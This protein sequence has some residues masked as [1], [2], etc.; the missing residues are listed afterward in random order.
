M[1]NDDPRVAGAGGSLSERVA[2]VVLWPF[3]RRA[4]IVRAE[5]GKRPMSGD[6]R[7]EVWIVGEEPLRID[8]ASLAPTGGGYLAARVAPGDE[9]DHELPD[10]AADGDPSQAVAAV[11]AVAAGRASD[12]RDASGAPAVRVVS[13]VGLAH[14]NGVLSRCAERALTD[15]SALARMRAVNEAEAQVL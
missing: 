14:A 10:M 12:A 9:A 15:R 1:G 8:Q 13:V 6:R 4:R 5:L 3:A 11:A 2:D 7:L